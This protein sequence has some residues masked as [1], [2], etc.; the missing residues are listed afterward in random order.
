MNVLPSKS[1]ILNFV[2]QTY[3]K[4]KKKKKTKKKKKPKNNNNKKTNKQ[5]NKSVAPV[6]YYFSLYSA[7][8]Y[9]FQP[10]VTIILEAKKNSFQILQFK[11]FYLITNTS[12]T[13]IYSILNSTFLKN[14]FSLTLCYTFYMVVKYK[15]SLC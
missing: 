13:F 12:F 1:F 14:F 4:K 3:K 10:D 6:K 7:Y 11:M 2:L 5:T 9:W 8:I 15:Y